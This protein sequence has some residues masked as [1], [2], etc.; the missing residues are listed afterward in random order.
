[1]KPQRPQIAKVILR[2]QNKASCI[3]IPDFKIYCKAIVIKAIWFWHK[4][5]QRVM[6]QN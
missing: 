4:N 3:T 1:M 6:E 5:G 2:R